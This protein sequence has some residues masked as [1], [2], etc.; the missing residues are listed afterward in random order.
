MHKDFGLYFWHVTFDIIAFFEAADKQLNL[1]NRVY[2][3]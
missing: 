2:M 3:L 1:I